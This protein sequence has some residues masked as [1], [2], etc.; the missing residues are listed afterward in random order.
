MNY[1]EPSTRHKK[2][3]KTKLTLI[4]SLQ[5]SE[6]TS[7]IK[8]KKR[9]PVICCWVRE[10]EEDAVIAHKYWFRNDVYFLRVSIVVVNA[11]HSFFFI[12]KMTFKGTVNVRTG[13]LGKLVETEEI[14]GGVER[15][16]ATIVLLVNYYGWFLMSCRV[17][18]VSY[19]IWTIFQPI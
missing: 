15:F 3:N 14:C 7:Y 10:D 11:W 1:N 5:V 12:S 16:P 4:D 19:P 2:Q 8:K 9:T 6:I 13:K 18:R 17:W